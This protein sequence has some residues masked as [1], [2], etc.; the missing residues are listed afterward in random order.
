MGRRTQ[1]GF[2][3]WSEETFWRVGWQRESLGY[4][5]WKKQGRRVFVSLVKEEVEEREKFTC[6]LCSLCLVALRPW[7]SSAA[8]LG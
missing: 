6:L 1:N 5:G 7:R 2:V 4:W 8:G 3:G